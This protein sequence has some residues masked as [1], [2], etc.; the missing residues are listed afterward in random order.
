MAKG[1]PKL[2]ALRVVCQRVPVSVL[3][4]E[5]LLLGLPLLLLLSWAPHEPAAEQTTSY[6]VKMYAGASMSSAHVWR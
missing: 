2:E 5:L 1:R 3:K 4:G 6:P